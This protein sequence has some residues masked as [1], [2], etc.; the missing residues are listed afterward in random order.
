[1]CLNILNNVAIFI[2]FLPLESQQNQW[3]QVIQEFET[4][5]RYLEPIMNKSYDYSS[6]FVIM[7]ALLKIPSISNT[8]VYFNSIN[9]LLFK[10]YIS[11]F[12]FSF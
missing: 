9:I 2:E 5:F 3:I 8:K 7:G 10:H 1:V 4:L 6:L 12:S 11:C